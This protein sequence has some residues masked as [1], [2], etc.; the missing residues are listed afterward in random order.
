MWLQIDRAVLPT[1]A[2]VLLVLCVCLSLS[3]Q[4]LV[5]RLR[6]KYPVLWGQLGSPNPDLY[7]ALG[8]DMLMFVTTYRPNVAAWF[9]KGEY[10]KLNDADI[11]LQA[12]RI[13]FQA[14]FYV[15]VIGVAL[16]YAGIHVVTGD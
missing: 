6:T 14:G 12:G 5:R 1:L 11:D 4:R 3:M 9:V 13:K 7:W 2:I 16:L 8:L 10:R 15:V